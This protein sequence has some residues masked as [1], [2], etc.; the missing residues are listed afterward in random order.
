V[1]EILH[2]MFLGQGKTETARG[3]SSLARSARVRL[4]AELVPECSLS[5][6]LLPPTTGLKANHPGEVPT[7]EEATRC[8]LAESQ[9]YGCSGGTQGI[10]REK[11]ERLDLPGYSRAEHGR[12]PAAVPMVTEN[13][14]ESE[15]P[16]TQQLLEHALRLTEAARGRPEA[17]RAQRLA[18]QLR[19]GRF[20]I[21]VVGE[22]KRGK[23]TLVNAL[24]GEDAV[25]T[26]VLPLT[27]VTTEL[28]CG[29]PAA[30]IEHLDGS[31][32][33]ID[34]DCLADYV[35]ESGNPGNEK[36]V[37]RVL[38]SG[39]W[40][41]L[42]G[43]VVLV[44]TPG[45]GSIH[46][47][48]TEA[49]RSALIEADGAV[50][51]L[52]ADSPLSATERDIL[53]HLRD[54]Q[55]P[56][57]FVLNKVDHL[58]QHELEEVRR[59]VAEALEEHLGHT[60]RVYEVDARAALAARRGQPDGGDPAHF[61]DL[62][63][64]LERFIS[65][66]LVGALA[67]RAQ[68]ELCEL[69][70]SLLEALSVEDAALGIGAERMGRLA[71]QFRV[72][73]EAE[74]SGFD[75][76]RTLLHRDVSRLVQQTRDR[77]EQR[78]RAEASRYYAALE[79]VAAD[80]SAGEL[81]DRL[82]EAIEKAVRGSFEP[83]RTDE[84]DRV[85]REWLEIAE[86]FRGRTEDRVSSVRDAA[87][88]LFQV[89]LPRVTIPSIKAQRERFF[90]LFI[91]LGSSTDII[92]G[93]AS[94]L[95]PARLARPRAVRRA[96]DELGRELSKHAGRAGWETAQRLDEAT[97]ELERAMNHEVEKAIQ[98]ILDAASRAEQRRRATD[99]ERRRQAAEAD[100]QRRVARALVAL[101][102]REGG[103]APSP[104]R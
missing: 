40:P 68:R 34:P 31:R 82:R 80:S 42:S 86:R 58:G 92:T 84:G 39:S 94:R 21:S 35:S 104:H 36:Q 10:E 38:V 89:E 83:L 81:A 47:H 49:A 53:T 4:L 15:A 52:S 70:R 25:P 27:A 90:Y 7:L 41:L 55:A 26:G 11:K 1:K 45:T 79:T 33:A 75:D 69:G 91:H 59:F 60:E 76:D 6:R 46:E 97:R 72:A 23:S 30:T 54:R 93:A 98:T 95:M 66:D 100:G 29:E 13:V 16:A 51:V 43:G 99:E 67:A 22:F 71:A 87:A 18:G 56:T 96:R 77:L 19:A 3:M 61:P 57:F 2:E 17:A 74:R 32:Q 78:A 50:V 101:S 28:S 20:S 12:D 85:E 44:D 9:L 62:L 103:S 8:R 102:G 73:A 48:N 63:A 5:R 14:P 64:A 37:A 24:L 88:E 65:E